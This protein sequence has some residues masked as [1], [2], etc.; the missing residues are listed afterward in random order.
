MSRKP[1]Q[2]TLI[3]GAVI[4]LVGVTGTEVFVVRELLAAFLLFCALFGVLGIAIL[5]SFLFGEGVVRGV[6][7]LVTSVASFRVR[8]PVPSV[9]SP[10]LTRGIGR[11]RSVVSRTGWT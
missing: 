10:P 1:I 6:D 8:Q 4:G 5:V 7:L 2:K 11:V 3:A 9:A